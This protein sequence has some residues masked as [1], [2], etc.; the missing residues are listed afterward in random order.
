MRKERYPGEFTD[1]PTSF[2]HLCFECGKVAMTFGF[3]RLEPVRQ[4]WY[5]RF[6]EHPIGVCECTPVRLKFLPGVL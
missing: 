1:G 3:T 5:R 6:D 4:E 2:L